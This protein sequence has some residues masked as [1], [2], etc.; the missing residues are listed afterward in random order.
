MAAENRRDAESSMKLETILLGRAIRLVRFIGRSGSI[1]LHDAN[2][3]LIERYG[4]IKVPTTLEEYDQGKG[5]TFRHG[6]FL[7][8]TAEGSRDVVIDSFQIYNNGLIADTQ[9]DTANAD[10]FLDD[11]ITWSTKTWGAMIHD[12]QPVEK[13]FLSNLEVSL[14]KPLTSYL[15]SSVLLGGEISQ[16]LTEYG[17]Q[18]EPYEATG[19][20]L[21]FDKTLSPNSVLSNFTLA[22][23]DGVAFKVGTYFSSAP[24]KTADHI[25][26]LE[27]LEKT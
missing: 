26:L 1:Y 18:H 24:L 11:V 25:A 7:V 5:I 4:F 21:H 16:Y 17:L 14:A 27:K 12:S 2:K 10:Q 22:R 23:R 15:P 20:T 8:D 9:S 6:K 19:F 3:A 13:I